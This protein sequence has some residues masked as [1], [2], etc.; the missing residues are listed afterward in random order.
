M[1]VNEELREHLE[2]SST[3][4]LNSAVFAEWNM[5][6]ASNILQI[7]NYRFRP[8]DTEDTRYNF[9]AQSFSLNDEARYYTDAT[10]ADIV[11]DGGV[12]D[13]QVPKTF[14]S[15]KEKEKLIYSLE[16]CF[17]KHR[18]RSGINKIRYF[19]DKFSHFSNS[20]MSDRPRYYMS[21]KD[22]GFKYWTSYRTEDGLERGVANQT[23]GGQHFIEDAA[24]YVVYKEPVPANRIVLK[25]QTNVGTVD[26]GPFS[27]PTGFFQD[28]F[29]GPDKQ[30]T[31]IRWKVQYLEN[32]S[33]VD[34]VVFGQ[35]SQRSDGSSVIGPDG[36]AE[37]AY[38]L[39]IPE[40]YREAFKFV[41]KFS[42]PSLL[43]P[44]SELPEGSAYFLQENSS[45]AGVYYI[46][47]GEQYDTFPANYGWYLNEEMPD[48][49]SSYI[50]NL[51][52]PESFVSAS[53]SKEVYREF[54]YVSG[55]RVVVET[56]NVFDSTFDLIE[57]SP[58]LA[59]DLSD[60]TLSFD[61]KRS[62]SD[63]GISG[64]PVSQL[65]AA[66][67]GINLFDFDQAFFPSN[68]NSIIAKY[69]TQNI[70]FKFYEIIIDVD[71][72]DYFVPIK[73]M[74]SEGFP[75][76]QSSNRNVSINLRDLFYYFEG[77]T[78]PQL[79]IPNVSVSYAVSLILDSVGFAN[80]TFKRI[81]GEGEPEIPFFF[82]EPDQ[83][84][85]QVLNGIAIST[86]TAMFF[87]EF[88]NFVMMS[89]DFIMPSENDRP[90]DLTLYGSKDFKKEGVQKNKNNKEILA[91]IID[92]ANQDN[93]IYNDG[94]IS[95]TTRYLQRSYSSIKQ[96]S[97]IDKEKT[98]I[99]KP[100]L[101]WEVAPTEQTKP[102]N[103]EV[104]EQSSYVLGAIPLNSNLSK[105]LPS[106]QNNRII[107]NII[108]LGD[109][110]YWITK[111]NGFFYSGGEI[112]KYD[113]VQFSI[114]GLGL[115]E[116]ENSNVEGDN[117]WITSA[118]E[119]SRYFSK[120]PFNG[121]IYP[122][123]LVRIYAEPNFETI[124][125]AT[126]FQN[127]AVAKHGRGQF[128]TEI[129]EHRAGLDPY[130]SNNANVRGCQMD[131]EFLANE[132]L[133][134]PPTTIGPA[135][136]ESSR[137]R[138]TLRVGTIKN[139]LATQNREEK[140][141]ELSYPATVQSSALVFNGTSFSS[142]ENPLNFISYVYRSLEN[143]FV[144]FGTR[145]RIIGK[146]EN[147]EVRGQNPLNSFTYFT[148]S[149]A[150]SDQ[151]TTIAGA[152]GGLAVMVNPETNN[153]Y[154]F[155]LLALTE[156]N[157]ESYSDQGIYNMLFYKIVQRAPEEGESP[158]DTENLAIPIR[159]WEGI[160]A[161]TVDDG[162]FTGQSRVVAESNPTVYDIAVE[163]ENIGDIRRFYLYVN[164]TV[165]GIVDDENP[166]P[167]FN[168]MA[169]FVRG[170]SECM[171]EN[172]YAL[173]NNYSQ[174]TTFALD[175]PVS[176]AF[177]VVDISANKSFQ[178]YAVSG[179][180]Q[181]TYLSGIG[182]AEPP[183]Y[184]IYY[185]EF[186]TIM[187]E[188]AYFDVRYDKAYPALYA[189]LSPTFNRLK[190]YTVS[191]FIAG[192][193]GAQFLIFN[194]TDTALSLDSTSGNYL[195]IQ[196]VTLTQESTNE[197]RVDD[198]FE[199]YGNYSA[200]RLTGQNTVSPPTK[201]K[202]DFF[203]VK[204]SRMTHGQ[205]SFSLE[206]PYI[207]SQDAADDLMGWMIDKIMKPRKS[208]GIKIFSNPMIQLG[209]IVK[210]NYQANEGNDEVA[211]PNDRFVV[212]HIDYQ[213]DLNGPTMVV[214]LS[215]ISFSK[216][217]SV[218]STFGR[219]SSFLS[220]PIATTAPSTGGSP[221]GGTVTYTGG[222]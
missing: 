197:L 142:S 119:Y 141:K 179:L 54:A 132:N 131:F 185:E 148:T 211:G 180:I 115:L 59:V 161:I 134:L 143:R 85:A 196:G 140:E 150:R 61:V 76:S 92:I 95:Y 222:Y 24:P 26:L 51:T 52:S 200:I 9:V 126:F 50:E 217:D 36:Y 74:Y 195:R 215:E 44:A 58:R 166:L 96:A 181:S 70:Q 64:M 45:D 67:G 80:Y 19:D 93:Q 56:M 71:G 162:L 6:I 48:R 214:F 173:T 188:A 192:A 15:K 100:V 149:E 127:G 114:P 201:F 198:Y 187:R 108:D 168:N 136:V 30:T 107:N 28:P 156:N 116:E 174:N 10:D 90:T 25:T 184:N 157:L 139:F 207:Q 7:G 65:L 55:L 29:F 14:L 204:L 145:M 21:D 89:K 46:V 75:Q 43:P 208:L 63:L 203:D 4:R 40:Q 212:Y 33:W 178:K 135:G 2:T 177:D 31:P 8:L 111:Y 79:F 129:V 169:L 205:I 154:Y 183:K 209:D 5:N 73:T 206:T 147:S 77:K 87:D 68:T 18:P 219:T 91:N 172:I 155:E 153:G 113:A 22:D 191:N 86:Q 82:V 216:E 193:Y 210:I 151:S 159:L 37:L 53:G 220:S 3:V 171:F 11:I 110:I 42:S 146:I 138:D 49:T 47:V 41:E 57:L 98:W 62:A 122:T 72:K 158:E 102:I 182:P 78:A 144:H 125:N 101:L 163:Y 23:V 199:K 104:G 35:N 94:S 186:G 121:K 170:S 112:I 60:K 202:E 69:T 128:S 160:G 123:G 20:E 190:G 164:N 213:R 118:Q 103:D 175:T 39:L 106:V 17:G 124:N 66:T 32:D 120:I 99:Y 105:E 1:F 84:V 189:K 137:A 109:G 12:D 221:G 130:W 167:V 16:D 194:A 176:S 218:S 97:L 133:E 13:L 165:V 81:E 34:A 117:V 152:S 83:S 88:N 27:G 38:G